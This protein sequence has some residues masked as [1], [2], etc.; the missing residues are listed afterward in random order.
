VNDRSLRVGL[1]SRLGPML[2]L[3]L[4][5][6]AA[7]CY[8]TALYFANLVYDRWLIDSTRSLAL[9]VRAENG[10]MLFAPP[11]VALQ[12]F[13]FDEVDQTYFKIAS[14]RRGFV[15]G[16]SSLP[17]DIRTPING[18]HLANGVVAGNKV[19]VVSTRLA[20]HGTSDIVTVVIAETL[21][22]RTTL[23]RDIVL[24]MAAP[25]V[26]LL[27]I[28]GLLAWLGVSLG[29]KP[30][31]NLASQIEARDQNN[32][33]PVPQT[34]LPREAR[35][36]AARI[37]ELLVRL[38]NA[39]SAQKRFVADAAHQL[40]TPLAAIMLQTERA[41]RAPDVATGTD[42][43]KSLHRSVER[44]ARLCQQL[45]SLARTEPE[46]INAVQFKQ[47]DLVAL[48]RRVGEEW[49]PQ[50][51]KHDVDFGLDAP[52]VPVRVTG[53]ER[54][55][56]EALSNLIDNALRY[57][58]PA[59]RVSVIVEAGRTPRLA[60][61]DDGPGIPE[62]ERARI[63]ERFY[64]IGDAAGDG[65]GLGLAIV[66]EVARVHSS[67]VEVGSGQDGRG[68]RFSLTFGAHL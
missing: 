29:L 30:L 14:R 42:A 32:L 31:T 41:Q 50:A 66:H 59:G 36:L 65:C 63:F 38:G 54:L 28:T 7:A 53:D 64:R 17:D 67:T 47:L 16:E 1:F 39:L 37:N 56:A 51:L 60:V 8:F 11:R 12:I 23:A 57:G 58:K 5:L 10:E 55:L 18:I 4:A 3:L 62:E 45:L 43:L 20:P 46:A 44:A 68:S 34:G 2:V 6:D 52:D 24:A 13:Q 49:I 61:Q 9:A 26:A 33:S 21:T 19:R 27:G 25:Q 15:A 48:A 22:K 40:R 35:V